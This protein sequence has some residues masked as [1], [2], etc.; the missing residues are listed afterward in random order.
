MADHTVTVSSQYN[1]DVILFPISRGV[2][3]GID[4]LYVEPDRKSKYNVSRH[5]KSGEL[6]EDYGNFGYD[7]AMDKVKRLIAAQGERNCSAV[8][9]GGRWSCD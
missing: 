4:Y 2:Y 3:A 7:D 9:G 6:I 8:T 5:K 1:E